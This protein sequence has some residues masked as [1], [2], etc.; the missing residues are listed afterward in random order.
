MTVR[1]DS[2]GDPETP[3]GIL[4]KSSYV[5]GEEAGA[6]QVPPPTDDPKQEV[7]KGRRKLVPVWRLVSGFYG[8]C[9]HV[10]NFIIIMQFRFADP[11]DIVMIL[12]GTLMAVAAGV[13]RPGHILFFGEVINQFVYYDIAT[14]PAAQSNSTANQTGYF[15]S[16]SSSGQEIAANFLL[17]VSDPD[18]TLLR[19]IGL[20]S[21]YYIGLAGGVFTAVYLATVFWNI[22]AYRQTRR[23]R[24]AF[25]RSILRQEIGW[26]D[27]TE[28]NELSTRLAE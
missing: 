12:L 6:E 19:E 21:L 13:G 26:F 22:S 25:Y 11:W 14:N 7:R 28:A 24:M 1:N 5:S 4:K 27:V 2:A 18:A 20:Y 17:F 3:V 8:F 23:M 10:I 9:K 15:C 16:D